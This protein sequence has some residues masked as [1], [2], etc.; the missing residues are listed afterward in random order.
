[1]SLR[2]SGRCLP[3]TACRGGDT[4]GGTEGI[5]IMKSP[6]VEDVRIILNSMTHFAATVS[7]LNMTCYR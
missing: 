5:A 4:L 3:R 7:F 2:A 6:V 1:M